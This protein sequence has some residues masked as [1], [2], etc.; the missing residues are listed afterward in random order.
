MAGGFGGGG[1]PT[2]RVK[3]ICDLTGGLNTTEWTPREGL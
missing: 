1:S 3:E 2:I